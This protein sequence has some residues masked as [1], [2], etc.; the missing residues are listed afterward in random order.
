MAGILMNPSPFT[1]A[2]IA[3]IKNLSFTRTPMSNSDF[4]DPI[5][6]NEGD[7]V[8]KFSNSIEVFNPILNTSCFYCNTCHLCVAC[9][10]CKCKDRKN[11][12]SNT[13]PTPVTTYSEEYVV[14]TDTNKDFL[15]LLQNQLCIIMK[16][17]GLNRSQLAKK[18]GLSRA[19]VTRFLK[20]EPNITIKSLVK[21]CN[22]LDLEIQLK[23]IDK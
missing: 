15:L 7:A 16:G 4:S 18:L 9:H 22:A 2:L 19:S 3:V 6:L 20:K 12:T 5:A 21:I 14:K 1:Y 11:L 17:K 13:S 8:S 23:F 10:Y